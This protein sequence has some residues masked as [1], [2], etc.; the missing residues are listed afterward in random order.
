MD[1]QGPLHFKGKKCGTIFQVACVRGG[2]LEDQPSVF[3]LF[4]KSVTHKGLRLAKSVSC[5][6]WPSDLIW[7]EFKLLNF[8][9]WIGQVWGPW[10][11]RNRLENATLFEHHEEEW[12]VCARKRGFG[13][14]DGFIS[15]NYIMSRKLMKQVAEEVVSLLF[16]LVISNPNNTGWRRTKVTFTA[17][18]EGQTGEIESSYNHFFFNYNFVTQLIIFWSSALLMHTFAWEQW[19]R[20]R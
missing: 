5:L 9:C 8:C 14:I 3:T 2:G 19:S 7:P 17:S 11:R 16:K 18:S 13:I 20:W 1:L 15:A 6:K 10:R 4:I 12:R